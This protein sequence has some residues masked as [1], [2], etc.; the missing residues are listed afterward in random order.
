MNIVAHGLWGAALTPKKH[1]SQIKWSV[2]WSV[3]PDLL[4]GVAVVPYFI[5]HNFRFAT[6]W[7]S[8][9]QWFYFLYGLGHSLIIWSIISILLLLLKKWH[10][11]M[12]FWILHILVDI[13]GHTH[14]Q[15]PFL[16]PISNIILTGY[17]SWDNYAIST[18]SHLAPLIIIVWKFKLL[19]KKNVNKCL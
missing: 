14:F 17:F 11:S 18:L 2:F 15:T 3:F 12:L 4:W 16:F 8:A 5:F 1:F 13:P 7:N 10:W 6:D 19:P 9:P